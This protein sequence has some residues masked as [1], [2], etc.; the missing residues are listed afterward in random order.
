MNQ[1]HQ[2]FYRMLRERYGFRSHV[3]KQLY[4]YAV[5]LVR[6]VRE[7]G[8]SK[9]VIRR[10]SAR[11]DRYDARVD[12]DSMTIRINIRGRWYTLRLKHDPGYVAKFKGRRWYEVVVKWE[13]GKLYVSIPFEFEYRPYKP[14]GIIAI[15]VNLRDV[16]LYDGSGVRYLATRF[17]RALGL[18]KYAERVQRLH[19]R[20]WR[21]SRRL[22]ERIRR[23]HRR[24]RNIII[25]STRKLALSIV[26]IAKR[27]GYAVAVEDLTGLWHSRAGN[28]GRSAWLLSR[29]AYRKLIHAIITKAVEH[30]VPVVLVEPSGTSSTC[31][32]CGARLQTRGRSV[33]CP[34]C[35]LMLDR[36]YAAAINIHR[37]A[38]TLPTG[39]RGAGSP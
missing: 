17:D 22:L 35:G 6:S 21:R 30:N 39:M 9:P 26:R 8:G 28:G 5:A 16:T 31:P 37:R 23:Y 29:F 32:R 14:R 20:T 18:K 11:L 36:D 12:L 1:A 2:M 34:R 19:P 4:K 13:H 24:A 3:A 15:D 33:V 25:D 7:N 38:S 27:L 10:L